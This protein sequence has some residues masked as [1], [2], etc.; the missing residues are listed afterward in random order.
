MAERAAGTT[1]TVVPRTPTVVAQFPG[2][3]CR[4]ISSPLCLPPQTIAKSEGSSRLC[5]TLQ[6]DRLKCS[7]Q[8][9][10]PTS[11]DWAGIPVPEYVEFRSLKPL[12][13]APKAKHD[14]YGAIYGA[15]LERQRMITVGRYKLIIYP[16]EPKVLLFDLQRDPDE[17]HDLS[18]EASRRPL[19]HRLFG[20]LKRW[21]KRMGDTLELDAPFRSA[22]QT[23]APDR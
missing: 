14:H 22:L 8:D 16:A 2:K 6:S 11:L 15:Y 9:V 10:V 18:G 7:L 20:E 5:L 12:V 4:K 19:L 1:P 23:G 13:D 21:Q 17:M 3:C